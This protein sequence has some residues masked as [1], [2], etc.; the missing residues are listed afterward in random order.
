MCCFRKHGFTIGQAFA[1][2]LN[3][4]RVDTPTLRNATRLSTPKECS[5]EYV[6]SPVVLAQGAE[7]LTMSAD[8][9]FKLVDVDGDGLL[10]FQVG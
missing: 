7:A 2:L 8:S 3:V 1:P 4:D 5:T 9:I 10:S 6:F